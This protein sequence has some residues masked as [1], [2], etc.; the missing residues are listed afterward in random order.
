MDL[1][2]SL[3]AQAVVGM[4]A[5]PLHATRPRFR[6]CERG[7]PIVRRFTE[8]TPHRSSLDP[9]VL[10]TAE[11]SPVLRNAITSLPS[12]ETGDGFAFG[13]LEFPPSSSLPA[14]VAAP[15]RKSTTACACTGNAARHA[16]AT[17][18]TACAQTPICH[19]APSDGAASQTEA[20]VTRPG[21]GTACITRDAEDQDSDVL[22]CARSGLLHRTSSRRG[23]E[24]HPR[25]YQPTPTPARH[26]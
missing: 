7:S 5:L 9:C 12:Y 4:S 19:E 21:L 14:T 10:C 1:R 8:P 3:H 25:A 16:I 15:I 13:G 2:A 6:K 23:G 24:A 22:M 17:H 26:S 20:S 18:V 11:R